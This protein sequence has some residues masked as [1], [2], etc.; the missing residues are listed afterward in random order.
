VMTASAEPEDGALEELAAAVDAFATLV[1]PHDAE[2]LRSVVERA[3]AVE[4]HTAETRVLSTEQVL[5]EAERRRASQPPPSSS[6]PPKPPVDPE[7]ELTTPVDGQLAIEQ[8]LADSTTLDESEPEVWEWHD[9]DGAREAK[10]VLALAERAS[11][12]HSAL[13]GTFD[14]ISFPRI[15][16][17]LAE[18]RATGA[19]ICVHPPDERETTEGTEPTKV[20]YFRAGVPVHVRSNL[21][22]EC[23]GQVLARTRRIGPVALHESLRAM[24]R[25]EGRQGEVLIEMGAIAPLELSEALAHQMRLKLYELFAWR[26]GT[27]RYSPQEKPPADLIDLELGLAEIAFKGLASTR[28]PAHLIEALDESADKYVVPQAR[29]LVRFLSLAN[30]PA[31]RAVIRRADGSHTVADL[32]D[33]A[34]DQGRAATLL[35]A[36]E[37]LDAVRFEDEPL[38][39]RAKPADSLPSVPSAAPT[40]PSD[41][42][43]V[44]ADTDPEEGGDAVVSTVLDSNA[45]RIAKDLIDETESDTSPEPTAV[46]GPALLAPEPSDDDDLDDLLESDD[47]AFGEERVTSVEIPPL[48]DPPPP[49]DSS[50]PP[51]VGSGSG[52][53]L[54]L[55]SSSS[56][57]PSEPPSR[58]A[59]GSGL[60]TKPE[61]ELDERLEKLLEAERRFRRGQRALERGRYDDAREAFEKAVRLCPD[62]EQFV[63]HLCW[64]AHLCAPEDDEQ[65]RRSLRET[66]RACEN[67]PEL[68]LGHLFRA[69]LLETCGRAEEARL[70]YSRVLEIEPQNS[71]ALHEL[72]ALEH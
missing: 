64:S 9:T 19:L 7:P 69:R 59:S 33:E 14:K 46:V 60:R 71:A 25:G 62:E 41:S 65:A 8:D 36:M 52:P 45:T 37:C 2:R 51:D 24:H 18:K 58:D 32:L 55:A 3:A 22:A 11:E 39:T 56:S 66:E 48:S 43:S 61:G 29:R 40:L 54:S 67:D 70:A 38:R 4:P 34:S 35:Y 72:H 44:E 50:A 5:L 23:L 28:D 12:T 6:S 21:L 31:L 47:N 53:S 26:R 63:V 10:E 20:V 49:H 1:G 57:I 30:D 17:R 68:A 15:L 42:R 13:A 27:F 16:H